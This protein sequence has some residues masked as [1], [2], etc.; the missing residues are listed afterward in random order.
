M[1]LASVVSMLGPS[2]MKEAPRTRTI[3]LDCTPTR[4]L[5]ACDMLCAML[6]RPGTLAFQSSSPFTVFHHSVAVIEVIQ[7]SGVLFRCQKIEFCS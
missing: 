3:P 5:P 1:M 6:P 2:T 4:S 7:S